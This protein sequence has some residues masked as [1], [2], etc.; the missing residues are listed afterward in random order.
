MAKLGCQGTQFLT[1]Y[2]E[3]YLGNLHKALISFEQR[4]ESCFVKNDTETEWGGT[5][6]P[7][8][9]LP[10]G[11]VGLAKGLWLSLG[12]EDPAS[13]WRRNKQEGSSRSC[14]RRFTD[15]QVSGQL[16]LRALPK[17]GQGAH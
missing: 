12:G 8:P 7:L 15:P 4:L 10:G 9:A 2:K 11:L 13:P 14:S 3:N 5:P 17:P 1:C 6:H 16:G